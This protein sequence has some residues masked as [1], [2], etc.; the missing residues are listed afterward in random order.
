MSKNEFYIYYKNVFNNLIEDIYI[1]CKK[2]NLIIRNRVTLK[3]EILDYFYFKGLKTKNK[4]KTLDEYHNF[5]DYITKYFPYF[6]DLHYHYK[7]LSNMFDDTCA[8]NLG[9]IL[10]RN[11]EIIE[12]NIDD[13]DENLIYD[14]V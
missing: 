12:K 2:N 11:T 13:N 14:I 9:Y 6:E 1:I 10:Y 4:W 7:S 5:I 3:K 8:T